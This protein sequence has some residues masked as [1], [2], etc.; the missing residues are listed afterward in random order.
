M[1]SFIYLFTKI[2]M[3]N[4]LTTIRG[5]ILVAITLFTPSF[6]DAQTSGG[7]PIIPLFYTAID[8]PASTVPANTS[9]SYGGLQLVGVDGFNEVGNFQSPIGQF[10]DSLGF[11]SSPDGTTIISDPSSAG[12]TIVSGVAGGKIWGSYLD[13]LGNSNAFTFDGTNYSDVVF[14]GSASNSTVVTDISPDY[15]LTGGSFVDQGGTNHGFL[16]SAGV[17][18]QV[19]MP[20]NAYTN[21]NVLSTTVTSVHDG[22]A[23]LATYDSGISLG[24]AGYVV[25]FGSAAPA[26]IY[27]SPIFGPPGRTNGILT[28]DATDWHTNG[29][30]FTYGGTFSDPATG[31]TYGFMGAGYPAYPQDSNDIVVTGPSDSL[32]GISSIDGVRANVSS[33]VFATTVVGTYQDTNFA[34]HGFITSDGTNYTVIDSPDSNAA[35]GTTSLL[36]INGSL[37]YGAFQD[38]NGTTYNFTYNIDSNSYSTFQGPLASTSV[39]GASSGN[40]VGSYLDVYGNENAFSLINGTY[41][42][43]SVPGS[44]PFSSTLVGISSNTLCGDY[45]D[46]N[47]VS[48][49]FVTSDGTNFLTIYGPQGN[50]GAGANLVAINGSTVLGLYNDVNSGIGYG[51]TTSDGTN[52]SIIYGPQGSNGIGT[53]PSGI[54]GG[55]IYGT[56]T[57]TN[58]QNLYGFTTANNTNYSTYFGPQGPSQ[59]VGSIVGVD[60]GLV[61]GTYVD[62]NSFATYGFTTKNGKQY[63]PIYGP[64]GTN[65]FGIFN[66]VGASLGKIAGN[67]TDGSNSH[68]FIYDG[69]NYANV[70]FPGA[71]AG[72]TTVNGISGT[73]LF[74]SYLDQDSLPHGFS[75]NIGLPVVVI[76][77][78][79]IGSLTL[80]GNVVLNATNPIGAAM[81][82]Y[83]LSGP[84]KLE[85]NTLTAL[86]AGTV[87]IVASVYG[88]DS[89]TSVNV[90]NTVVIPK[91]AQSIQFGKLPTVSPFGN[92]VQVSA[93]ASPSGL[94]VKLSVSG[95]GALSDGNVLRLLG[96]GVITLSASQSGNTNYLAA[97][98]VTQT[99]T[100]TKADPNLQVAAPSTISY[101]L[102][103]KIS[104]P[105]ATTPSTGKITTVVVSGPASIS[106]KTLNI[107]GAG[108]ITLAYSQAADQNYNAVTNPVT[109]TITVS[110]GS[111]SLASFGRLP[112]LTYSPGLTKTL[113]GD[114][115]P[116][117]SSGLPVTLSI[118]SGPATIIDHTLTI[119]GAGTV[120]LSASQSGGGNFAPATT[121]TTSFVVASARQ[122]IKAFSGLP[123]KLTYSPGLTFTVATPSASS[124]L[125]VS[126]TTNGVPVV[127]NTVS[128]AGPGPVVLTATQAGDSNY[129]PATPVTVTL[130]VA[131]PPVRHNSS[132]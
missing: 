72:T 43:I 21:A 15:D 19:D 97:P 4:H 48:L 9:L 35:P 124:G 93:V 61:V 119:T 52:Y 38:A 87:T 50:S 47:S 74:G 115:V 28:L 82:Y 103:K 63:S 117:A 127:N 101:S 105:A 89:Y 65:G 37:V 33:S 111:Q 113:T 112:G 8:A 77:F 32:G 30:E 67:Y 130:S 123:K 129:L 57:D 44:T 16:L 85:G 73:T 42:T 128:V 41:S 22:V 125:P 31:F 45:L 122:T 12:S 120:T 1:A 84:G 96:P 70:D 83:V 40:L 20:T 104:V 5:A 13:S 108:T 27:V 10:S 58:T 11:E 7:I 46:S 36:G 75:A 99:I 26:S 23:G 106:G 98:T 90:T 6:L 110:P 56:Y 17:Y 3:K 86:G 34:S 118:V 18:T 64:L 107:S 78:P 132:R 51:F 25:G 54:S 59:G 94:P 66:L 62:T 116:K 76:T 114:Q 79:P 24:F 102:A 60:K 49:G 121:V 71:L 100:V 69:T 81:N 53:Y 88:S 39:T 29:A 95:R 55:V 14:P 2:P 126:V 80:G 109:T 92:P 131:A 91:A 68:G